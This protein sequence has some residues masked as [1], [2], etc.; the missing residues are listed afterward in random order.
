MAPFHGG[1]GEVTQHQTPFSRGDCIQKTERMLRHK[2]YSRMVGNSLPRTT[3]KVIFS[4]FFREHFFLFWWWYC[5]QP[6]CIFFLFFTNCVVRRPCDS[7]VSCAIFSSV[8]CAIQH[9]FL[10][11]GNVLFVHS[12]FPGFLWCLTKLAALLVQTN[13]LQVLVHSRFFSFRLLL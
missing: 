13:F 7:G 5:W 1:L 8:F 2:K 6:A 12:N 10:A 9:F 11:G 3:K 4:F